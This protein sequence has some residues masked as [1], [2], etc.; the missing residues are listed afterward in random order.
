[1]SPAKDT[2]HFDFARTEVVLQIMGYGPVDNPIEYLNPDEDPRNRKSPH[3]S[4][5]ALTSI[6]EE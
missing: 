6:L 2:P 1:M 4:R 3:D 5:P